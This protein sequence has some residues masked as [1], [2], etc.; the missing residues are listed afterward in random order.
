MKTTVFDPAEF[1]DTPEVQAELIS[2][3]FANGDAR[4]IAHAIGTVAR[5][6]GMTRVSRDSGV[7]RE[8][9]Y[10]A[11]SKNGDPRLSTLTKALTALGIE[12]RAKP[13]GRTI[14]RPT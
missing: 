7:T 2:E 8:A 10:R 9:L 3:A 14:V 6:Q 12:L 5:A 1:L 13:A 4:L 11:L